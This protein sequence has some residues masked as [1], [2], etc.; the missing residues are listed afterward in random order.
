MFAVHGGRSPNML[1]IVSAHD[2]VNYPEGGGHFWVY[3]QYVQGLRN[4]GCD[5][6]WLEEFC[7]TGDSQR[8]QEQLAV[9]SRRLASYGL[10]GNALLYTKE[11]AYLGRSASEAKAILRDTDLLLNFHQGIQPRMLAQVR[12]TALVDIDPGLLQ[13]W[14]SH[15]QLSVAPHDLYFTTGETVGRP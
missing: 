9:F 3:L 10:D 11:G 8:D 7:S 6:W 2:V 1:V 13:F 14:I 4:A 5:V 12:R 15:G